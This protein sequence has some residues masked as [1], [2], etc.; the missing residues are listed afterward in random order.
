MAVGSNQIM[1]G[2]T[3]KNKSTTDNAAT[4]LPNNWVDN[5]PPC[6][7]SS[8]TH[9]MRYMGSIRV[10][11]TYSR[12]YIEKKYQ[13][14]CNSC[15]LTIRTCWRAPSISASLSFRRCSYCRRSSDLRSV[16][17]CMSRGLTGSLSLPVAKK[18]FFD[19]T[20]G[21]ASIYYVTTFSG[22]FDH[23]PPLN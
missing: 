6:P 11:N 15:V 13:T 17:R 22:N 9:P 5:C 8:Y 10:S 12:V 20:L 21:G 16:R 1:G 14:R 4:F 3:L 2:Q 23:L 19:N 7:S 18:G